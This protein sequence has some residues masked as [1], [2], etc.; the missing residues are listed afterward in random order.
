MR[1]I[2]FGEAWKEHCGNVF[3]ISNCNTN[4]IVAKIK[5]NGFNF[6]SLQDIYP[7]SADIQ[8][9]LKTINEHS[10]GKSGVL[11]DGYDFDLEYQNCIKENGNNLLVIDDIA[12]LKNYNADIIVNQNINGNEFNYSCNNK[13]K[14][15]LGSSYAIIRDD[16]MNYNM[17]S[18]REFSNPSNLLITLGG[19]DPYNF[20]ETLVTILNGFN[21]RKLNIKVITGSLFGHTNMKF[22]SSYHELNYIEILPS[23]MPELMEWADI[24]ISSGGSTPWELAFMGLPAFVI[25]FAENQIKTMDS[26]HNYGSVINLGWYSAIKKEQLL[27]QMNNLLQDELLRKK[28]SKLGKDLIDGMGRFRIIENMN[29]HNSL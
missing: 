2:A 18:V 9:T 12:H 16:F 23:D 4:S 17:S 15:L 24:A 25:C 1:C 8:I 29:K 26:L 14:L 6:I 7:D 13:T 21:D 10:E 22:D 20:S 11:I 19:S 3:I 27:I 5:S 28:M